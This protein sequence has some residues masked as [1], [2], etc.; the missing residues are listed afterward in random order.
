[1]RPICLRRYLTKRLIVRRYPVAIGLRSY[2]PSDSFAPGGAISPKAVPACGR[3]GLRALAL[4][5]SVGPW[6]WR[7][8]KGSRMRSGFRRRLA[9]RHR[10]GCR[11]GGRGP[12]DRY[13]VAGGVC[14]ACGAHTPAFSR[15]DF[16]FPPVSFCNLA[17]WGYPTI[18]GTPVGGV[19]QLIFGSWVGVW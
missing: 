19:C 18:S 5:W 13:G 10:V 12:A 8:G 6:R 4:G 16:P 14:L 1:M 9:G 2:A 15:L 17:A 3:G 7:S 11:A